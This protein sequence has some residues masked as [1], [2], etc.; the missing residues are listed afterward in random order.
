MMTRCSRMTL[1]LL[2]LVRRA[3][4]RSEMRADST[5]EGKVN[6]FRCHHYG[7]MLHV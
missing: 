4:E 6:N 3:C 7:F 5:R 1:V 2:P